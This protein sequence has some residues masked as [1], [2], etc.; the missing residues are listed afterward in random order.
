MSEVYSEK[1]I[2]KD[3]S[4]D[5][6]NEMKSFKKKDLTLPKRKVTPALNETLVKDWFVKNN[7]NLDIYE[8]LAPCD[9]E[10]LRQLYEMKCTAPEFYYKSLHR[11]EENGL[12]SIVVFTSRLTSLF[13]PK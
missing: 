11:I 6:V 1:D 10:I 8:Y 4:D 7:L 2:S 3:S 12:R 9:G 13:N 5:S